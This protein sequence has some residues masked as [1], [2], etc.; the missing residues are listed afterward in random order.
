MSQIQKKFIKDDAVDE[1]KILLLNSG[2]LK[3]RNAADS[4][5]VELLELDG[6][7]VLKLLKRPR[8]D[9]SV[10]V[11]S[12]DAD[13]ITKGFFDE[14]VTDVLGQPSGIAT[15]DVNGK[16]ESSQVP[17]IAITDVF[18][19]ADIAARD[20]LTGIEEGDV[21]KVLDAGA[22]LPKTYIYDGS[23]WVEIESGSDVDTVNGQTGTVVLESDDINLPT[24]VRGATEVQAALV[25]LDTD[26]GTA[27]S[28]ITALEGASVEFVQEKFVLSA[29][30]ITNGYIDLANLAIAASINAFVD[31][32]AIH[33][34]DDYT[35]STVSS[36][37]R[38]T[39]AGS[40]ITV[41]QEK[42]SAGD[43]VRVKYAKVA[44]V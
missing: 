23:A 8:M 2:A 5:N 6:S 26:L 36:V 38:I 18:V 43:V 16:L 27:E 9:A 34:T 44:I 28:A 30:D 21:A 32:L 22:G 3:A 17:A 42:L 19:V 4:A 35:L 37:T 39:F 1:S 33:S 7:D 31:R 41:G 24:A 10:A 25:Q 13:V 14:G 20:A 11:V 12:D 29:G 15:L 40:L